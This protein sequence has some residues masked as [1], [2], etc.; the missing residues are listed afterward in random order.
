MCIDY[1][2]FCL[3]EQIPA[4]SKKVWKKL[5]CIREFSAEKLHFLDKNRF[6]LYEQ[7]WWNISHSPTIN[8]KRELI[9]EFVLAN[10]LNS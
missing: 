1:Y 7:L 10:P 9:W 5:E 3:G 4:K 2:S 8:T 6:L